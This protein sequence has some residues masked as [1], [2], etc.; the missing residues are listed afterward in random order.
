MTAVPRVYSL[1]NNPVASLLAY[2]IAQ[3]PNQPKV[4]Q[5]VL[6]LND[7]KKL[8]RFL[9]NDSK[10]LLQNSEGINFHHTQ[11][12]ASHRPPVYSSGEVAAMDNFIVSAKHSH[13]MIRSIKKFK[14]SLNRN[15]NVLLLNPPFGT[16]DEL[17]RNIWSRE[18]R[19]NIIVG[20]TSA[21]NS[22]YAT[23]PSE[24]HIR[25]RRKNIHLK[26]SPLPRTL[27]NYGH[28]Q[29][30]Q[31][32][33]KFK[34]TNDLMKVIQ[35]ASQNHKSPI[36][37]DLTLY[38]HDELLLM[39]LE[40][41][42][43]SSCIKP[44]AFLF[45]CYSKSELLGSKRALDIIQELIKEQI[46]ILLSSHPFLLSIPHCNIALDADRLYDQVIRVMKRSRMNYLNKLE[47]T[48]VRELTGYFVQ[49]AYYR[50]LDCK[51]NQ[52]ITTL[53]EGKTEFQRHRELDYL[54]LS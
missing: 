45:D 16:V 33:Q 2:E 6:L 20:V 41:L 37:L 5:V 1:V 54:H 50:K 17:Y 42:I 15:S 25:L 40:N 47:C 30:V 11:F 22:Y 3:L 4:S 38:P 51:W 14:E 18:E 34:E 52:T 24:F 26:M 46:S 9:D 48:N 49:L 7:R 36:E 32:L 28:E 8:N 53:V 43:I 44:L 39:R 27:S 12:M 35:S 31:D 23:E 29:A 13:A 10:L 21:Q 19:P